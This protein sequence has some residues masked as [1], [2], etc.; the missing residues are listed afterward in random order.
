LGSKKEGLAIRL[1]GLI[2]PLV[3]TVFSFVLHGNWVLRWYNN[4]NGDPPP[5]YPKVTLWRATEAL[6][7]PI[8][9]TVILFILFLAVAIFLFFRET[10]DYRRGLII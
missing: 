3:M 2:V 1:K 10:S 7:I 9:I 6:Q 8:A 5:N 4:I